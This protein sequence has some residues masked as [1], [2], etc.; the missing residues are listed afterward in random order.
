MYILHR[1]LEMLKVDTVV[2]PEKKMVDMEISCTK[3]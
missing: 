2:I 1:P 3:I